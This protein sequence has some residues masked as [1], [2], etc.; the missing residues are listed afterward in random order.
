MK[1]ST[2]LIAL[3]HLTLSVSAHTARPSADDE[4]GTIPATSLA[5]SN[6]VNN[7]VERDC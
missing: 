1:L 3:T 2:F 6:N 4:R 5:S 7:L